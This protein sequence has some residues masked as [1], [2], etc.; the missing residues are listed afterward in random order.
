M[1]GTRKRQHEG[2]DGDDEDDGAEET[3]GSDIEDM[4]ASARKGKARQSPAK[5]TKKGVRNGELH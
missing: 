4:T 1:T 3:D 5:S 2:D